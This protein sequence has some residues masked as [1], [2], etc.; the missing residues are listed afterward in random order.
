M[1]RVE[2]PWC[3][4]LFLHV[5]LHVSLMVLWWWLW[6]R[7]LRL[8]PL[9]AFVCILDVF[10]LM[11]LPVSRQNASSWVSSCI[12]LCVESLPLFSLLAVALAREKT[13][14]S[15][16]VVALSPGGSGATLRWLKLSEDRDIDLLAE[17][18]ERLKYKLRE[19]DSVSMQSRKWDPT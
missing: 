2:C 19:A 14:C 16:A 5:S 11:F 6:A 4:C 15:P 17:M 10:C 12:A 13:F 18:P 3:L 1:A 8:G 9:P 7:W